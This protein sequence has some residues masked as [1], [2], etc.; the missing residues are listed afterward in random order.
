MRQSKTGWWQRPGAHRTGREGQMADQVPSS[1]TP[2]RRPDSVRRTTTHDSVRPDDILGRVV[3]TGRGRDLRTEADGTPT[4]IGEAAVHVT[5]QQTV[6][7]LVTEIELDPPHPGIEQLI[8]VAA[9]AGFRRALDDAMPGER[10]TGSVR[11]QILD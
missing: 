2:P 5:V 7:R 3:C 1:A 9:S 6:E 10:E 11:Y 8:G 4:V